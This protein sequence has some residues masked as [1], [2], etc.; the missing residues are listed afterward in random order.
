MGL[1]EVGP[2]AKFLIRILI[3][4]TLWLT[5]YYSIIK[6]IGQPDG[7]LRHSEANLAVSTLD[8]FGYALNAEDNSEKSTVL[9]NQD[10]RIIGVADSCNGLILFVV[11]SAFIIC[12][13]G[14]IKPKLWFI[15]IGVIA[16]YLIN[17]VRIVCL[18]LIQIHYPAW[19]NFNHHY[20]F[21]LL[22]YGFIFFLWTIY[23]NKIDTTL[24]S[25]SIK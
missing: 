5:L 25:I 21:T 10:K 15:P 3:I 23:I 2:L 11:F 20:V 1:R 12:I 6:P 16:I 8:F 18:T 4:S 14:K 22:V 13:P 19:L 24:K 17:V 9:F 7:F